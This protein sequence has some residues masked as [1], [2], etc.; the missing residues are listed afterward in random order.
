MSIYAY[1]PYNDEEKKTALQLLGI[2]AENIYVDTA[3]MR[4]S[5][6]QGNGPA[7][8][9]LLKQLEKGDT[10]YIRSFDALGFNIREILS[11]WRELTKNI[12]VDVVVISSPLLDTRL[13]KETNGS[14]VADVVAEVL[15]YAANGMEERHRKNQK[16]GIERAK[17]R[18]VHCGRVAK[19]L[20]DNFE[21]VYE[22][23]KNGEIT[24]A[25]AAKKCNMPVSTFRYR[26]AR[27]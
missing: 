5:A 22:Q 8:R 6:E 7:Y 10:L 11:Q 1:V 19:P 14:L 24:G 13:A 26:A 23:W 9:K 27:Y 21:A 16:A 15:S 17:E 20:P 3:D 18:G 2:P 25:E 12:G 4:K